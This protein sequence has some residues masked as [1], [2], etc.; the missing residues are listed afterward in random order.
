MLNQ[1]PL[2][3]PLLTAFIR[4]WLLL[5][6]LL[7]VGRIQAQCSY[8][9]VTPI[10]DNDVLVIQLAVSGLVNANLAS[11][12]Q[13]I[14]GV[15]LQFTHEY[16]GDL[17]VTV[18]SPS[19]TVVTLIG[20]PTTAIGPTNL[21]TWDIQFIPCGDTPMPDGTFLPVWTNLQPWLSLTPY[22]GSYHPYG[23]C[24][25]DFNTGSANGLWQII[26]E[27]HDQFQLGTLEEVTLLFCDPTGLQCQECQPNAGVLSPLS[28][29]IC[30]GENIQSSDITIDF[31]G[32][33]P[34][35][36]LYQYAYVLTSGNTILQSGASF[37]FTP[38]VG[39]YA[40]CGLSYLTS[41][42]AIVNAL[43]DAGDYAT[44]SQAIDDGAV[45][46]D[47]TDQ[48]ISVEVTSKPDTTVVTG[49]I[50]A[51]E[52]FTYRGQNY[53]DDGIFF[54]VFDGPGL[55]DTVVEIRIS[56]RTLNVL[57]PDPDTLTCS[58]GSVTATA[59]VSGAS[60]PFNFQ[61]STTS[62]NITSGS[63]LQ[64]I[65]VDQAGQYLVEVND[66]IC[67]GSGG[68]IVYADQGYPQVFFE[69]GTL[70]CLH[71]VID[72][73]PIYIPSTASVMWL[74][75]NGFTSM[76]PDIQATEPGTY[77]FS[78]TNAAGCTTSRSVDIGIDTMTYPV[79]IVEV[80]KDCI[81]GNITLGTTNSQYHNGWFWTGPNMF[82]SN[83]WRP[84]ITDP[85]MYAVT[86]THPNG[87]TRSASY[88]AVADFSIPDIQVSPPDTLNCNETITL[89]AS[90]SVPGVTY[91][92]SGPLGFSSG[93]QMIS[94]SQPG[95]YYANISAP[96]GCSNSLQVDIAE[97]DD[98]FD[99]QVLTD[100]ITC[101]SP[102][103]TIGIIAP[104]ADVYDWLNYSGP[105]DDS[106]MIQVSSGGTYQVMM[107]DT[108][109]GCVVIA[110]VF[111]YSDL[112]VPS[113][114]YTR[115]TIT[116]L[117]P[118]AEMTFIPFPGY[119]Y[120]EVYWELPDLTIIPGPTVMSSLPG[121]HRL[122]GI[123]D[124][125]C[126]GV[127]RV[128]IPFDTIPPFVIVE[129]DTLLCLDTVDIISQSLDSITAHAWTGPG[130]ISN[131]QEFVQV[132]QAGWYHLS[133]FGLNGCPA[134]IDI[135]VD[136]NYVLPQFQLQADSLRC[137]QPATLEIVPLEPLLSYAWYDPTGTVI[138]D[139]L[140]VDINSPGTYTSEI[141]GLNQC[142]A[143]DSV[144]IDPLIY[145]AVAVSS[146]TLTCRITTVPIV[147]TIPSGSF[148]TAWL[149]NSGNTITTML[150]AQVSG[151]G[152]FI[153]SVIGQNACE[154]RDTIL[155]PYDTI[156]PVAR[157]EVDGII[158]CQNRTAS[159]GGDG[160]SPQPLLYQWS[161]IE[162]TIETNP[163]ADQV[164][165]RDTG[166]YI[167]VVED[168]DNGCMDTASVFL[169]EDPT[170]ISD[171]TFE[172]SQ[173]VCS[174]EM[175]ASILVEQ[176]YGGIA[177]FVYQLDSG[178]P[179]ASPLFSDLDPGTYLVSVI[180]ADQCIFDSTVVI[181]P[182]ALFTIDAGPDQEIH[183]GGT[184]LL[185]GMTDLPQDDMLS[186][187]WDS[188]GMVLCTHCASFEVSPLETTTYSFQVTSQTGCTLT[189]EMTVFVL[190]RAKFFVANIFSPNGD[191]IN[192][193][194]R[195]N[196]TPGIAR[197]LKW[198]IFDRWGNAVYGRTDFD[199][200]DPSV[201][202]DG[203]TTT[204]EFANPAVFPYLI[205]IELISGKVELFRGDITLIR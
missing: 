178:L 59:M 95:T 31:G 15:D 193:E 72:I 200:D 47:L 128:H 153:A 129:A 76:Q 42:T 112:T 166:A 91:A 75:P 17:T 19:G 107:T 102:Q 137:D 69:G 60:G 52:V 49:N 168:V 157:I 29:M 183:I 111:A 104:D 188:L 182:T 164:M 123:G 51:G 61:W 172:L 116:C 97:G 65:T 108:Q 28:Y 198:I 94:V 9:E 191:G 37:S 56:P 89:T 43:V 44:L 156:Q 118:V 40:I 121:E 7:S 57:V 68:V 36:G 67:G 73:E 144:I 8:S 21:S 11:P 39:Q 120:A 189:D 30:S 135:L 174:G 3:Q 105:G 79:D 122:Y 66:G 131:Q 130:I 74:F 86:V 149:D 26:V 203:R 4:I 58:I 162:G 148:T 119:S 139:Q 204:G 140:I 98:L 197:V 202:W 77:V 124:N 114:E 32:T 35:P 23:G 201:F 87:C 109:T 163:S 127:W 167:L 96:N 12:L 18:I 180:D 2:S 1:K 71:P 82:E 177:P 190:N 38:P 169:S 20:P 41:D 62:G 46:A 34:L 78:V 134:E 155:V 63:N 92:W 13:G 154:T 53:T 141:Q 25:E 22:D 138:S 64:T 151:S 181:E 14:C 81:N 48:C 150:T 142:I 187:Q 196:A 147:M 194:V 192:D 115:D 159:L 70:T 185:E 170:A 136:S 161:T 16:L 186:D 90:S 5:T 146:D 54:Q 171:A 199:P 80:S 45:C 83:Y 101:S 160:S 93:N 113:F 125:G 184:A 110:E 84:V 175:N 33:P 176:V 179:Q 85:G 103:I 132:N 195:V 10:P 133:A 100:T 158:K 117:H 55:C 126:V 24:L 106:P 50:C 205:E 143:V 88:V 165:V 27:D 6:S 152:P 173:P 145:P 99:F